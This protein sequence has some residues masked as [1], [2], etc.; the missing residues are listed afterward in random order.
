M[1]AKQN[2]SDIL[3]TSSYYWWRRGKGSAFIL[4]KV[5]SNRYM[6][7]RYKYTSLHPTSHQTLSALAAFHPLNFTILM[8]HLWSP[9][10]P[11]PA[12]DS[13]SIKGDL[14]HLPQATLWLVVNYL[15]FLPWCLNFFLPLNNLHWS[16]IN[17]HMLPIWSV[18]RLQKQNSDLSKH[19]FCLANVA[20]ETIPFFKIFVDN[21]GNKCIAS[22][23]REKCVLCISPPLV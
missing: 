9:S 16:L 2:S 19:T 8:C 7:F 11:Q 15:S 22:G 4:L 23:G 20:M 17:S 3:I 21:S 14:F 5:K 13:Y 1:F 10:S 6:S 12:F 18:L